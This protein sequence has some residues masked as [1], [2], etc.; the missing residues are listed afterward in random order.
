MMVL[1]VYDQ[2]GVEE[3]ISIG[4][5]WTFFHFLSY[6]CFFFIGIMYFCTK[7]RVITQQQKTCNRTSQKDVQLH[8]NK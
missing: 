5:K 2:N 6:F 1:G 3:D 8:K 4:I 7:Q